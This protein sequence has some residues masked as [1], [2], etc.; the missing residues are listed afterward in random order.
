MIRIIRNMA[1]RC[2]KDVYFVVGQLIVTDMLWFLLPSS[3]LFCPQSL[4][5]IVNIRLPLHEVLGSAPIIQLLWS[6]VTAGGFVIDV[7]VTIIT[8]YGF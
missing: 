8:I 6:M 3:T 4:L 5:V 2:W 7:I 1:F